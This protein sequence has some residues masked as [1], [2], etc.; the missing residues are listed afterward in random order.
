MSIS[1]RKLAEKC[2]KVYKAIKPDTSNAKGNLGYI[3][4]YGIRYK[5]DIVFK[6]VSE[7]AKNDS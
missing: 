5:V 4:R 7:E 3:T 6:K 2:K 1:K